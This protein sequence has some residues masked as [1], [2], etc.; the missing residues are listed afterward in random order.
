MLQKFN[1]K[2][3]EPKERDSVAYVA[4]NWDGLVA[5]WSATLKSQCFKNSTKRQKSQKKET[6]WRMSRPTG[7]DW[8]LD[9]VPR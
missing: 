4:A 2:T 8:L 6:P 7:M 9:G 3:E 5:G 1:Q